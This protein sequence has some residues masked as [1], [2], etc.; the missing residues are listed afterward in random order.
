LS[1]GEVGFTVVRETA[2]T[3]RKAARSKLSNSL[4]I[5]YEGH[6][7]FKPLKGSAKR[8]KGKLVRQVACDSLKTK[9]FI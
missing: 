3:Q 2:L 4:F 6:G 1:Q 8:L 7:D 9:R 5:N